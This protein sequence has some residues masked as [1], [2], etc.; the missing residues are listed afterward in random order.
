LNGAIYADFLI[1]SQVVG[2]EMQFP[3]S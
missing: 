1:F 2:S 3:R